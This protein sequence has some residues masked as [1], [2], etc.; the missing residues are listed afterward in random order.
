[1]TAKE[2]TNKK[3]REKR[4]EVPM[5][6][7]E[8]LSGVETR[9]F[10]LGRK[11]LQADEKADLQEELDVAQVELSGREADLTRAEARRDEVRQRIEAKRAE[12]ELLPAQI[13]SSVRRGK[14][15]QALRQALELE[16]I[17]KELTA[18][19]SELPKLEQT[20]WSLGF[21]LRQM[22]RRLARIRETLS[23]RKS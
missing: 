6:L 12:A 19:E 20:I 22:R 11:L 9:L 5:K 1:M 7:D 14:A 23:G 4:A 18:A 16:S 2:Q 3:R 21:Y 15:S 17:R 13:E 10:N 8:M